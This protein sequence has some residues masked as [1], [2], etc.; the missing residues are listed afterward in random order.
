MPSRCILLLLDGLGDRSYESLGGLT[1]LQAAETP[2]LDRVASL[3]ANGLFHADP[4]LAL[5][6]E[7]AHFAMFGYDKADFP[8]RGCLEA[9][10]AGIEIA[11]QDVAILAHFIFAREESGILALEKDRPPAGKDEIKQFEEAV[12]NAEFGGVRFEYVPTYGVD[13]VLVLRGPASR[14]ITDSDPIREGDRIIEPQPWDAYAND[15]AAVRTA[16]ALREYLLHCHRLLENH[17]ANNARRKAG[18]P[19]L[20]AV[21]TNRAGSLN[22]IEPFSEKWDMKGL[23][24]ASGIVYHGLCSFLGMD[25]I[26]A[27]ESGY[28]GEDFAGR[29]N[30]ALSMLDNYDFIH[31]HTKAPDAASHKKDPD[32]KK[33][34]IEKLDVGLGAVLDRILSNPDILLVVS[35]DHSTPCT[36]PLVHSAEPV[37]IVFAGEG[38]RCDE[39][40]Q[41]DEIHCGGG[42]LGFVRGGEL[43]QLVL[44][45][46]DRC[47]LGGLMD[48]PIDQPYWPGKTKPFRL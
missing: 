15:P 39:V 3:G 16:S 5:P 14:Y 47:K 46:L 29:L 2:N 6:S 42:A 37:P 17:P 7:N 33:D 31:I 11:R 35:S 44:N 41:F 30:T 12:R 24:I 45:G 32:L 34:A 4:F 8:G 9:L 25:I 28:P 43:M 10:G 40:S 22:K 19:P 20:N 1:P 27:G 26:K 23:S 38:V 48:T 21:V 13:G 36:Q 18:K